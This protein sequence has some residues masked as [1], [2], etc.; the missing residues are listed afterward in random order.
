MRDW[1]IFSIKGGKNICIKG[2]EDKVR[3]YSVILWCTSSWTWGKME[4][5]KASDKK[6]LVA[7]SSKKC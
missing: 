7:R 6:L 5:N 3:S 4:D 2:W 1:E